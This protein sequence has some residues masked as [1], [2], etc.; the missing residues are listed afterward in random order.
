VVLEMITPVETVINLPLARH[1][2]RFYCMRCYVLKP[3]PLLRK[4]SS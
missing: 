2:S 1:T 4:Q 3:K